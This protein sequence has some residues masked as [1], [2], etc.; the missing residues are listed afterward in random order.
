M[1]DTVRRNDVG[2]VLLRGDATSMGGRRPPRG[3][4]LRVGWAPA[5]CVCVCQD[6]RGV[7]IGLD[8]SQEASRQ[9][10]MTRLLDNG[11]DLGGV[12]RVRVLV[13]ESI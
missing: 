1:R 4:G 3:G 10:A 12:V 11:D 6:S 9:T 2:P 7:S 13:R 8:V 5:C